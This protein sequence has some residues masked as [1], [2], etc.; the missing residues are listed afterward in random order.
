LIQW[1]D[2]SPA[3]DS[4]ENESDI[5]APTLLSNYLTKLAHSAAHSAVQN[6]PGQITPI[7]KRMQ[8]LQR[9]GNQSDQTQTNG[10][11]NSPSVSSAAPSVSSAVNTKHHSTRI[12][13]PSAQYQS[14]GAKQA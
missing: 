14:Y 4:W 7:A 12:T 2:Y 5:N 1:K 9:F 10:K 6:V 11:Q 8:E 3:H 13:K